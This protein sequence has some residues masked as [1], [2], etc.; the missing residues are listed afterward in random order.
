MN[1]LYEVIDQGSA[2][3]WVV[4]GTDSEAAVLVASLDGWEGEITQ[5]AVTEASPDHS[6]WSNTYKSEDG[7]TCSMRLA[8]ELCR[9]FP[10]IIACSEWP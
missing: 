3:Y 1:K 7:E 2:W 8:F 9:E 10:Q 5:I 4:A 6:A